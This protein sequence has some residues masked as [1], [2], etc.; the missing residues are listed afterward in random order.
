MNPLWL[1]VSRE[2]SVRIRKRGFW[3]ATILGVVLMVGITFLPTIMGALNRVSTT[4]VVLDDPHSLV[5]AASIRE[6]NTHLQSY[7]FRLHVDTTPAVTRFDSRAMN[8]YM[9]EHHTKLV[10]VVEG[11]SLARA[12]F[13]VEQQ[14]TNS[15][16]DQKAVETWL[17]SQVVTARSSSLSKSELRMLSAPV[18]FSTRQWESGSKSME[19]L[20]NSSVLVYVL[21]FLLFFTCFMYGMFVAQGLVEE[22]SNRVVEM[23][24]IAARPWQIL[25][26]KIIGLGL[27]ALIQYALWIGGAVVS[28]AIRD[29]GG[30]GPISGVPIATIAWFPVFF[31][32]G[33]L[34]YASLFAIAGSLVHR[35]ED[36]QMAVAPVNI[37]IVIVFY[38]SL[39]SLYNPN[40]IIATV[41]S[42]VPIF[43]PLTMFVRIAMTDVPIWQV[44]VS[45]ALTA[46]SIW[47]LIAIGARTYRR[48]S[49]KTSGKSG[50]KILFRN[51]GV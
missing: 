46:A 21:L 4:N 30:T 18:P 25:F 22:K 12:S 45:L 1:L 49:L 41:A 32:F 31:V 20:V 24:L 17:R 50:W 48:F 40:G 37:P 3:I 14:G 2:F 8:S 42:F 15:L 28:Y 23:L 19:Q 43:T 38:V 51:S 35:T 36:L 9:K 10:V 27:L 34:M 7:P 11:T 5:S 39:Y 16:S 29:S 47:A 33:Y 13:V 6:V 26:G 44:L